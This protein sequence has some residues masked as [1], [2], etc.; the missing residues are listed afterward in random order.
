MVKFLRLVFI[1]LLALVLYREGLPWLQQKLGGVGS[2]HE[3]AGMRCIFLADRAND[4]FGE[5]VSRVSGPGGDDGAWETFKAA[6]DSGIDRAVDGCQCPE[7]SCGRATQAMHELSNVI[8]QLDVRRRDGTPT[9]RN[10]M[11]QQK[12]VHDLLNQ[13]RSLARQGR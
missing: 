1:A 13:A 4:T 8:D 10:L 9:T 2:D 6:V 12:H 11:E 7:P 3:T 5:R